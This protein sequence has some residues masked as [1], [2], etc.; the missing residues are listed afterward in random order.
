VRDLR[1]HGERANRL[2][3][4]DEIVASMRRTR[5]GLI[6]GYFDPNRDGVADYTRRLATHLSH[7]GQ[8]PLIVTTFELARAAGEGVVGVAEQWDI[9]GAAAAAQAIR[10][11]DLDL[12]HVQFAPS[13][14]G[15]S[16]AVG[17][18]PILLSKRISL[19][20]TL[21]E[22]G[23]WSAHGL[24]GGVRS[25]LWSAAERRGHAD[26]E[27]LL[28]ARGADCVLVS[29][30]EQLAVLRARIRHRAPAAIEVPIGLN[31]DMTTCGR[32]RARADVR[33]Q[34]G[35]A[36]DSSLVAFFGFLHPEKALDRLIAAVAALRAQDLG[37]QLLL[38]GGAESHSVPSS[39][40]LDLRQQLQHV[41]AA[42]GLRDQVH[43]TGYLPDA[44]V[45]RL[46]VAADVAAF[47]LDAGVTR[48]SSSLLAA[49]AAGLPAVATAPKGTV[50]GLSE[51]DGVLWVPPRDTTALS[52]ALAR[53]L[54]DRA[55]AHR[56]TVAGRA[57]AATHSW[58]SIVAVHAQ[59]YARTLSSRRAG[60]SWT[61]RAE[62]SK[63]VPSTAGEGDG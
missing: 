24:G 18:L 59:V 22:Y 3:E 61:A 10:R 54:S 57:R 12:V 34:L 4:V 33:R 29:S 13:V 21:H 63:V 7:A 47:P 41:A 44:D 40:A 8:D 17:L 25:A 16:R 52:D 49:L 26:R 23:V 39:A 60:E 42:H 27:T 9:R 56:L 55:L 31:V 35:A 2:E 36:P 1:L 62:P 30:P 46:L 43:F 38:I 32:S 5:V 20:V 14:F 19:I 53:V 28:L 58:E 11:L 48:K 51:V 37:I 45:S 50:P 6:C 15:F